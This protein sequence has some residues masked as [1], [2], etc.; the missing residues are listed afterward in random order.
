MKEPKE[1]IIPQKK[2]ENFN[3][4]VI[5]ERYEES[6]IEINDLNILELHKKQSSQYEELLNELDKSVSYSKMQKNEYL[7]LSKRNSKKEEEK[8]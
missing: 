7:M 5:H 8:I 6:K 4:G 1:D 3:G 2:S